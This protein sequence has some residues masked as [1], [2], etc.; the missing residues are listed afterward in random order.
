MSLTIAAAMAAVLVTAVVAWA[1]FT[2]QRL[3][4]L[5]I[6]TD[7]ALLSLQGALDRRAAVVAEIIPG[8]RAAAQRAESLGLTPDNFVP[9]EAAERDINKTIAR[10]PGPPPGIVDANTRVSLA[11][12]FY[13]EAV[14]DTR[15]LRLRPIVRLLRLGGTASLPEFFEFAAE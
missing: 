1:Y 15:A 14:A 8:A 3:N 6:R 7:S 12:R 4:R 13:N 2:A 10:I 11:V 5:H 9:R